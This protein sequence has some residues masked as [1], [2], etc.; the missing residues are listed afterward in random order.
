MREQGK[1][2]KLI[3]RW[4]EDK[5]PVGTDP[6]YKYDKNLYN[7]PVKFRDLSHMSMKDALE[8]M[9]KEEKAKKKDN[10]DRI[11]EV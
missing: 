4:A 9:D 6:N 1:Q 8:L 2:R 5:N 11:E 10:I 7:Q 3:D